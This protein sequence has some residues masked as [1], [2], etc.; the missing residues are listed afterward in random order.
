[1]RR[2]PVILSVKV[3]EQHDLRIKEF[4][5]LTGMSQTELIRSMIE[6]LVLVYRPVPGSTLTIDQT[7]ETDK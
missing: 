2:Y 7:T 4:M 3:T 6:N 1:M 5:A